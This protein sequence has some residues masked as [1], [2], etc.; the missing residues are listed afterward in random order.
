M[1]RELYG[2]KEDGKRSGLRHRLVHGEYLGKDDGEKDY[3][4]EIHKRIITH[5]NFQ[6]L[7]EKPLSTNIVNPQRHPF[8]NTEGWKG[9]VMLDSE[10]PLELKHLIR[11]IR[12]IASALL[13]LSINFNIPNSAS[14]Y[15][16]IL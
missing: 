3:V 2:T 9:F 7:Q 15:L 13:T 8:G 6:I 4:E 16:V 11:S 10:K 14:W 1:K 5:F 12:R